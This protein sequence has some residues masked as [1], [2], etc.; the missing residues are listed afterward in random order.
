[1]KVIVDVAPDF[2]SLNVRDAAKANANIIKTLSD[3]VIVECDK[4]GKVFTKIGN[5]E[6]VMS[7]YIKEVKEE[8]S[9]TE[10]EEKTS[11]NED[12]SSTEDTKSNETEE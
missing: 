8:A 2:T 10:N 3:G 1:M 5:G 12:T 7:K 6:Y 9:D 11:D 4:I